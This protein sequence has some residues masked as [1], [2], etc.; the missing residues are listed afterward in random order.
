MDVLK[1]ALL[2]REKNRMETFSRGIIIIIIKSVY[3]Y[4][5]VWEENTLAGIGE[6]VRWPSPGGALV[7]TVP[8]H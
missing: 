3:T 1:P 7:E 5:Y 2:G 6:T 8:V 4:I